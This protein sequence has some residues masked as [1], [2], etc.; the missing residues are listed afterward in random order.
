MNESDKTV[1]RQARQL[2]A[3]RAAEYIQKKLREPGYHRRFKKKRNLR[4]KDNKVLQRTAGINGISQERNNKDPTAVQIT[5]SKASVTNHIVQSTSQ[6]IFPVLQCECNSIGLNHL[7]AP[8]S[9]FSIN[10]SFIERYI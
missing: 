3:Q 10:F 2:A 1:V 8:S 5:K 6:N 4:S 7:S 9:A